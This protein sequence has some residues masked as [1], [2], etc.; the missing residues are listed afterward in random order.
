MPA[1]PI[2][3]P[4]HQ[5]IRE[6]KS[7]N[8]KDG[9]YWELISR[10]SV[11]FMQNSP[12]KRGQKY[13]D[14][15]GS[16][17][18]VIAL[19]P[20]G[21]WFCEEIVPLRSS[22]VGGMPG[23]RLVIW[24]WSTDYPAQSSTNAA[25]SYSGESIVCPI[26]A[27]DSIIRRDVYQ[28]TPTVAV[29]SALT[30]LIGVTITAGGTGYTTATGT[31]GTATVDFVCSGGAIIAGIVTKEGASITSGAA[32]TITGNGTGATATAV[33]QP[34]GAVLVHQ[35][36]REL[37]IDSNL[38]HE[39]VQVIRVYETLPG[40]SLSTQ[41]L[42]NDGQVGTKTVQ[43]VATSGAT[44]ISGILAV[45]SDIAAE[46]TAVAIVTNVTR[47]TLFDEKRV[48]KRK[49]LLISEK[50]RLTIP[51][52]DTSE[53]I[54]G[55]TANPATPTGTTY[56]T[57]QQ[58]LT[59]DTIRDGSVTLGVS[60]GSAPVEYKMTEHG[61]AAL[62]EVLSAGNPVAPTLALGTLE[63]DSLSAGD[64]LHV[65]EATTLVAAAFPILDED[66]RDPETGIIVQVRKQ[67]ILTSARQSGAGSGDFT[68]FFCEN[69]TFDSYRSIQIGSKVL[70]AT[71]P[72]TETFIGSRPY[73][74]FPDVLTALDVG[75]VWAYAFTGSKYALQSD[76]TF[77]SVIKEAPKGPFVSRLTREYF[78]SKPTSEPTVTVFRAEAISVYAEQWWWKVSGGNAY[79]TAQARTFNISPTL[80]AA[81]TIGS[82]AS[83]E[84]AP[85][86]AD[87]IISPSTL[88]ATTPTALPSAGTWLIIDVQTV[89]WRKLGVWVRETLEIKC[90]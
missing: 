53:V 12:I 68:G 21:L 82:T 31:V 5:A 59:V 84:T 61:N 80:H 71:L 42:L 32:I 11:E 40:P 23:E 73:N 43:R 38:S 17:A 86:E 64:G 75:L 16:K 56:E 14:I 69:K 50:L 26:Y 66:H 29:G 77:K 70:T 85:A 7:P 87:F 9:Y 72:A 74:G 48:V 65:D 20:D 28:T 37:P 4:T 54:A 44:A 47:P 27:R 3:P 63:A 41:I 88:A 55:T 1:S 18:S 36:K 8:H 81:I 52:I 89:E 6:L 49:P 10:D 39:F 25:I 58:R 76:I 78:T 45:S 13:S 46:S 24:L 15:V 34:A 79:A 62:T 90:Q 51:T 22:E 30:A 60:S 57:S 19:H 2:N 33:I 35:E 83:G 67:I